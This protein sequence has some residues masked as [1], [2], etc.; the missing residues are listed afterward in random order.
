MKNYL[1]IEPSL[2]PIFFFLCSLLAVWFTTLNFDLKKS[3]VI[4]RIKSSKMTL[5]KS[6]V[7]LF[8]PARGFTRIKYQTIKKTE[9]KSNKNP[10]DSSKQIIP[11]LSLINKRSKCVDLRLKVKLNKKRAGGAMELTQPTFF[12]PLQILSS[13]RP[14][15]K[16]KTAVFLRRRRR[17]QQVVS[18]LVAAAPVAGSGR[19]RR[20]GGSG[21][22][23]FFGWAA[24]FLE[25]YCEDGM[26]KK[27]RLGLRLLDFLG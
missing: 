3:R 10:H 7:N 27:W 1:Q 19:R 12:T 6:G 22:L 2:L 18:V 21:G 14:F 23:W 11:L 15:K 13:E 20:G 8:S 25:W 17:R 16:K 24:A 9:F 5:D 4:D 26:W